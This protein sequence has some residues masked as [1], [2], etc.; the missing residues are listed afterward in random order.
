MMNTLEV[1]IWIDGEWTEFS[2]ERAMVKLKGKHFVRCHIPLS[3][4]AELENDVGAKDPID[5]WVSARMHTFF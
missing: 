3:E 4:L 2:D 1:L 5:R